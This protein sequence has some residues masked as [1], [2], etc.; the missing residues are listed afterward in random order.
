MINSFE[1]WIEKLRQKF[2]LNKIKIWQIIN[3]LKFQFSKASTL[4][5][6]FYLMKK[7]NLLHV[8]FITNFYIIKQLLWEELKSDLTLI[9]SLWLEKSLDAFK[10][11]YEITNLQ[12]K[13]LEMRKNQKIDILK[14][15]ISESYHQNSHKFS[16]RKLIWSDRIHNLKYQ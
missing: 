2:K 7:I 16:F 4:F 8:T 1:L 15:V 14:T 13:K 10:K 3:V 5:L 9:I 11:K 12:F 6:S